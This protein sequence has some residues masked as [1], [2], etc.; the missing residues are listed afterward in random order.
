MTA[1][2][3]GVNVVFPG[4]PTRYEFTGMGGFINFH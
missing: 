3:A 1:K 4:L 2:V